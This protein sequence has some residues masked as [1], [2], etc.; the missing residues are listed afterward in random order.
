[1][2][3]FTFRGGVHPLKEKQAGKTATCA[4]PVREFTAQVVYIPVDMHI[5]APSAPCVKKGDTVLMGQKIADAVGGIGIPVHASVSGVVKEVGTMQMLRSMASQYIA[6]ENDGKDEWTELK[7]LGSVET[8][9]QELIVPA[10]KEAGICGM[11]GACFPT[12]AK[13]NIPEGKFIDTVIVNGAE[14]ETYLTA[15]H[16]LML[17]EPEKVVKG[18]IA[19]MRAVN[20]KRGVIAIENNKLDAIASMQKAASGKAN[21]EVAVLKTK[22]PQGGEKQLID[23]VLGRQ[24]PSGGLPMDANAVVINVGTSKAVCEAIEEGKPLISRITTVTGA[25]KEPDNLLLRIG[26]PV[27][28]AVNACGGYAETPGKILFGGTMTGNAI[29]SDNVPVTK[30]N[31]GIV[32]LTEKEAIIPKEDPC[33]RCGRC[34]DVCPIY[35]KPNELKVKL[36]LGRLEEAQKKHLEDCILCGACSYICPARRL[37]TPA[38]KEGKDKLA[39]MRRKKA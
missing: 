15:D 2:K 30:A 8:V 25:V 38:F 34:V 32:V 27:I 33:I 37:L 24:V 22:Y 17:E 4:K 31:N 23:A 26:T 13:L 20:A 5:G 3:L 7:P 1:M 35:L 12:H 29:P 6:I 9:P 21:I 36:V 11:G 16:R 39:M 19:A 18:L 28:D 10:I 14:C